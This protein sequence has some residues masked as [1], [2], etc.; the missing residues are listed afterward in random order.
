MEH[1]WSMGTYLYHYFRGQDLMN[2]NGRMADLLT[3]K[4]QNT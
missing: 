4:F 2:I 3:D 1:H